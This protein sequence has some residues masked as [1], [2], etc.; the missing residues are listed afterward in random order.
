MKIN[1][2]QL[3]KRFPALLVH[4]NYSQHTSFALV[5][6]L[7]DELP[8]DWSNPTTTFCD[9]ACGRGTFLI[10]I[11]NRLFT[12]L[13]GYIKDE[14]SR[15]RHIVENQLYGADNYKA[16][17]LIAKKWLFG[18]PNIICTNSLEHRWKMQFDVVIGNP[19]YQA[20]NARSGMGSKTLWDKFITLGISLLKKDGILS[21]ITPSTW[22]GPNH[23]TL[24]ALQSYQICAIRMMSREQAQYAFNKQQIDIAIDYYVVKNS[25]PSSLTRIIDV[26]DREYE[27]D[28]TTIPFIPSVM[29]P[30]IMSL[31]DFSKTNNVATLY[32]SS[33]FHS[34]RAASK[35][36][37]AG[38]IKSFYSLVRTGPQFRY[39][40]PS[41]VPMETL[42]SHQVRKVIVQLTRPDKLNV[43]F[44]KQ[45][46]L[47]VGEFAMAFPVS[48]D[49]EG[50]R[51]IQWFKENSVILDRAV[52]WGPTRS[53]KMFTYL[54][55]DFYK[56]SL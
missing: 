21:M 9:P 53:W 43:Y 50:E 29:S 4:N 18:G 56:K 27:T 13:A 46:D 40:D 16:A 30:E 49:A 1:T 34:S 37:K 33:T 12:G 47:V 28:V 26:E 44:D 20:D 25:S 14:E 23:T 38:Y 45:G 3:S 42:R 10:A 31:F 8:V 24:K 51:I 54:K 35:E 15:V 5:E 55:K 36:A 19:P 48:S 22:R 39:F 52:K 2:N 32:N 11:F 6:Q 7:L 17:T 41:R